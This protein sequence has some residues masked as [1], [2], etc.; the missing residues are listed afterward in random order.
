MG[1]CDV[2][3]GKFLNAE[4]LFG[5]EGDGVE[6]LLLGGWSDVALEDQIVE[7]GADGRGASVLRS[8]FQT[9]QAKAGEA[10]VP[11]HVSSEGHRRA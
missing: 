5:E 3:E 11:M 2:I 7:V 8:L 10:G 1:W 6:G 4:D 9:F